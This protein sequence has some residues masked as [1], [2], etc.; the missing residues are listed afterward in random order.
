MRK[1]SIIVV[2]AR[3]SQGLHC[4]DIVIRIS[5]SCNSD[6]DFR[7]IMRYDSEGSSSSIFVYEEIQSHS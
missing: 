2:V 7:M 1:L 5:M 4:S 3:I 6:Q